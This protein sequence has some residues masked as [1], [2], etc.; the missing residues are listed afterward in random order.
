MAEDMHR[1]LSLDD[2]GVGEA[3]NAPAKLF[4]GVLLDAKID[5]QAWDRLMRRYVTDPKNGIP[6][7]PTKRSS[8]RSN[9]NRALSK[10]KITWRTFRKAMSMLKPRH[11]VYEV[12]FTW[13]PKLQ[14]P[15]PPP[16]SIEYVPQSRQ[17]EL[18]QIVRELM[19]QVGISPKIW[20]RL[21]E[22][23][24]DKHVKSA[25]HNPVDRSTMRGNIR[26]TILSSN[27]Y[28]WE[29]FVMA[30]NILGVEKATFTARLTWSETTTCRRYT[31]KTDVRHD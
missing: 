16:L 3:E 4:R 30:L 28:T 12:D 15:N 13:D 27:S 29:N 19:T 18:C 9:L 7:N 5:R 1:I 21:I 22:R 23:Y 11:I 6:N 31:F 8:E 24:L 20:D 2:K 14:L 26:K 25:G 17:D 10:Q